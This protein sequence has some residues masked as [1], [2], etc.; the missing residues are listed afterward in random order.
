MIRIV[1]PDCRDQNH[2]KCPGDAWDEAHDHATDCQCQCHTKMIGDPRIEAAARAW[3]IHDETDGCFER[4]DAWGV[5]EDW[6]REAYPDEYPGS[7]YEDCANYRERAASALAAADAVDPL[8]RPGHRV[9]IARFSWTLQHPPECR[10]N[11]LAC[12]LTAAIAQ[13]GVGRIADGVWTVELDEDGT[14]AFLPEKAA[15]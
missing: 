9:E 2:Q 6:E 3:A 14:L 1:S 11:M 4:V 5:L 10:P 8:R 12:P 13:A 15:S 7:D